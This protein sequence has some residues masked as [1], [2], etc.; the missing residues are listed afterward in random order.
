MDIGSRIHSL[1]KE[2]EWSQQELAEIIHV[3]RQTI[4]RWEN[5]DTLPDIDLLIKITEV[6]EISLDQLISDEKDKET[7]SV[8]MKK[9]RH[10]LSMFNYVVILL[11]VATIILSV[12]ALNIILEN[13]NKKVETQ[14]ITLENSI[15]KANNN[16]DSLLE[17]ASILLPDM[18]T[19]ESKF[20]DL[21][22]QSIK[23]SEEVSTIQVNK[24]YDNP[25]RKKEKTEQMANSLNMRISSIIEVYKILSSLNTFYS[26]SVILGSGE[27]NGGAELLGFPTEQELTKIYS[28]VR[29]LNAIKVKD[30]LLI[31]VEDVKKQKELFENIKLQLKYVDVD[32]EEEIAMFYDSILRLSSGTMQDRLK[33]EMNDMKSSK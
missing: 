23:F 25:L 5:G 9:T 2:K 20:L 26:E 22:K 32:N 19:T 7:I 8:K 11:G 30:T 13:N 24:I 12:L 31:I 27:K 28:D 33:K 6:F 3:S 14:L 15:I 29:R 10:K 17:N 4:S 1:R 21:K 18:K 16:L